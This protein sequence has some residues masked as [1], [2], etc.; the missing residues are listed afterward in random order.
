MIPKKINYIWLG[1]KPKSNFTNICLYS[2]YEKLKDYEIIE[3]NETNINL[4]KLCV[5]NKFLAEC[6]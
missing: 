5:E 4:E 6:R 1:E 3:W 2:W